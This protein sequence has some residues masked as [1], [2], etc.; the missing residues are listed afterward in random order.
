EHEAR[1]MIDPL[2]NRRWRI[3]NPSTRNRL[4]DPVSYQLLPGANCQAFAAANSSV[5]RRAKFIDHHLW[6]TPF[7]PDER[8][9]AG[10]YPN[11]HAG[12]AGLPE[13]TRSNRS[14]ESCD[15]VVWYTFG[16]IHSARPEEWP[17][18]PIERV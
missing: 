2:T 12:G 18:M 8:Y 10:D 7:H 6:V 3:S 17:V 1:Q 5:R 15:L 9:P 11:Q 13:W 14:I 4:G 16:S